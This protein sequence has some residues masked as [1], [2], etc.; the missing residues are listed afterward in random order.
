MQK[1]DFTVCE[2]LARVG[3]RLSE[4]TI[5]SDTN[6]PAILPR[7]FHFTEL[8]IRKYSADVG[9][10]GA[11]HTWASLRQKFWITKGVASV[12]PSVG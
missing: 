9:H 4:T 11:T 12:R 6:H 8:I 2:N 7:H 1:L 5:D 3:G 10:S